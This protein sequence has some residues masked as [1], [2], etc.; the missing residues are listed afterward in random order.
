M[1]TS[2]SSENL[3]TVTVAAVR[4]QQPITKSDVRMQFEHNVP[5]VMKNGINSSHVTTYADT[6]PP[7]IRLSA[8]NRTPIEIPPANSM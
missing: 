6:T 4:N 2:N 3:S 7:D 1:D 5:L 8:S